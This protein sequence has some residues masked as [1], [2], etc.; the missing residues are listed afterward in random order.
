M[1]QEPSADIDASVIS[2]VTIAGQESTITDLQRAND[3]WQSHIP[4][5]CHI[6]SMEPGMVIASSIAFWIN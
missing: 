2:D 3:F 1:E 5:R 4:N 6:L